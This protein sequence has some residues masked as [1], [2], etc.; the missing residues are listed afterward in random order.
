MRGKIPLDECYED[1]E[2]SSDKESSIESEVDSGSTCDSDEDFDIALIVVDKEF[3]K[4]S[5]V[6]FVNGS[7]DDYDDLYGVIK[8]QV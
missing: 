7:D 1:S 5:T 2:D 8:E 6:S 3:E 4:T